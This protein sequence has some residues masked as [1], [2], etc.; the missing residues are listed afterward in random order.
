MPNY[1]FKSLNDKEF[2]SLV[3]D[4]LSCELG[5]RFERFKSGRDGGIDARVFESEGE[6][7]VQCK[8]WARTSVAQLKQS[9][10]KDELEK[11]KRFAPHRYILATSLELSAAD[12]KAI[13]Q[14]FDPYI[15]T[16]SDVFGYEDLNDLLG[17]Y[18]LVERNHYKLWLN[19]ATVIETILNAPIIGRSSAFLAEI[20]EESVRY[21]ETENH[22]RAKAKLEAEGVV[23]ITGE[24]GIGKTTLAKQLCLSYVGEKYT[25]RVIS[26]TLS[27]AEASFA[28]EERI[29]FYMDDFLGRNYLEA[30]E[31]HE[32]AAITGFIRRVAKDETKRF[33]LTSR[34]TV[35][36]QAK[37][38]SDL[39]NIRKIDRNEFE[40]NI[41]SLSRWDKACILYN[42]FWHSDL[43][44]DYLEQITANR[45]Y[46]RIVE[47]KNFNPRLIEFIFDA[48]RLEGVSP[49]EF[50]SHVLGS[51]ENPEAIW[52][53][54][55]E[56]Q[57]DQYTRAALLLVSFN[58]RALGEG[59]LRQ[60]YKSYLG[61]GESDAGAVA[62]DF[63]RAM[64][65]AV[66]SVLNRLV[67]KSSEPKYNLFNPSIGDYLVSRFKQDS[68]LLLKV[69][70]S[71]E[72]IDSLRNINSLIRSK[73]VDVTVGQAVIIGLAQR[74][75]TRNDI[76][77][78]Y[79]CL[80]AE[81]VI[82][83]YSE[84]KIFVD[85]VLSF[86]NGLTKEQVDA[87]CE[88]VST[89]IRVITFALRR[90][91]CNDVLIGEIC[92][93]EFE[94]EEDD[95][96]AFSDLLPLLT[97]DV[98][99]R[100]IKA[101][102]PKLLECLKDSFS[103]YVSETGKTDEY[104]SEGDEYEIQTIVTRLADDRLSEFGVP[105]DASDV[106][107]ISKH[108]DAS[109][110]IYGNIKRHSRDYDYDETSADIPDDWT[111]IDDMF[112]VDLPRR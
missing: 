103:E 6:T 25:L 67:A 88:S 72:T 21:V 42:H 78:D 99:D 76:D 58:G 5:V 73:T 62:T 26:G 110:I 75:I 97:E 45:N 77:F 69:F 47:H 106:S 2:E 43:D 23:L 60:A 91:I 35:L 19:S 107:A 92:F 10:R 27:E 93:D 102:K 104:L 32:D 89:L 85:Q 68:D 112:Q 101:I 36:N 39:F 95:F 46:A 105:Y 22:K 87:E 96:M 8:H 41:E 61:L 28:P 98:H 81:I 86:V 52:N 11:V 38:L 20:L 109:D 79:R 64:S 50:W 74:K 17:R 100:V 9:L 29:I 37:R 18:P 90:K 94:L 70:S 63:K 34:S 24:P 4:L 66:G 40:I 53:H 7:I 55:F 57:L 71:L 1:D 48:Q 15:K 31:K 14:I 49:S 84:Y 3:T 54:V 12:K 44:V 83:N 16:D 108:V 82:D 30:I 56:Q 59:V 51:L 80:L 33:I 65:A 13:R 111:A